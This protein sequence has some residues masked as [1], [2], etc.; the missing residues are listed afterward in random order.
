[1][2]SNVDQLES[3]SNMLPQ[4]AP[5]KNPSTLYTATPF[6]LRPE[7]NRN[8]PMHR[9]QQQLQ[10]HQQLQQQQPQ[11]QQLQQQQQQQQ[12]LSLNWNRK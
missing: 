9:Q 11:Q 4:L 10:Q 8:I 12:V 1:M 2:S 6:T 5:L 3:A 7:M